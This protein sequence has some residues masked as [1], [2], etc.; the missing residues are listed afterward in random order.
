MPEQIGDGIVKVAQAAP[1]GVGQPIGQ[2]ETLAGTVVAVRADGAR[3]VL[4]SG[5][6]VYQGDTLESGADGAIGI[7]LADQTTFSMAENG[8]MVFDKMVYDPGAQ[9]GIVSISVLRGVF[10]FVSGEIAK[11]DPDAMTVATPVATIGIRG[12]Q[13]ALSFDPGD[14]GGEGLKVIL[15][16]ES[17][18]LVGEIVVENQA[19]VQILNGADMGTTAASN[20][21]LPPA[22]A[23]FDRGDI[24]AAFGGAL[25][26][27]PDSASGNK[28]GAEEAAGEETTEASISLYGDD[29]DN[30]LIGGTEFNAWENEGGYS[31]S[32]STGY[33]TYSYDD[34]SSSS[35]QYADHDLVGGAGENWLAGG[36]GG[37]GADMSEYTSTTEWDHYYYSYSGAVYRDWEKVT[38]TYNSTWAHNDLYGGAGDD[39]LVGGAGENWLD[40]GDGDDLVIGGAGDLNSYGRTYTVGEDGQLG[41]IWNEQDYSYSYGGHGADV[42]MSEGGDG[43]DVVADFGIDDALVFEGFSA[44]GDIDFADLLDAVG[45]GPV[46]VGDLDFSL[47]SAND[48]VIGAGA[49]EQRTEVILE[50]QGGADY[51]VSENEDGVVITIDAPTGF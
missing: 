4:E 32:Y 21:A 35:Q 26:A 50:N 23:R 7:V 45:S 12:A 2:V 49:G 36:D 30:M 8:S 18:G 38:E 46:I 5:D 11:T 33:Y 16:E 37:D 28:Y 39:A 42:F 25:K 9:E 51:S 19:G 31:D 13:M 3:V 47:N 6:W 34:D 41:G 29:G 48:V 24:V 14:Q 15:M 20:T 1:G 44:V 43:T 27:L 17:G 10:T 22:P 40:G